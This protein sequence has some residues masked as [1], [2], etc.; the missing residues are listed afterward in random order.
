M[1]EY[2]SGF[3]VN[4]EENLLLDKKRERENVLYGLK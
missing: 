3:Y 4:S 1:Q 2:F